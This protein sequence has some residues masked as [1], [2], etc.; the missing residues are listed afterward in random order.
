M[1]V[2]KQILKALI[3]PPTSW[4][5]L[6]LAVLIF[7][8]R[9]WA[10]KLLLAAV[11]LVIAMHSGSVSYLL[12]YPLESRYP[13]LVDPKKA[14]PYDAIVVLTAGMI[15][16]NGLIP[17]PAI[18]GT[19]FRRLDEA[20]RLYRISPRPIV[21]SGG[22]V[23]P[24]TP[25]QN[26]N[27][28]ACDYLILWGVPK[29]DVISEPRSRDTFENAVEV[30]KILREKGWKRY[31][32]VTSALHMPRS[33]LALRT[34]RTEPIPAPADFTLAGP[35]WRHPLGFFPSDGAARGM[36]VA[37]HEYVGI[38]NYYWRAFWYKG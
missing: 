15:P 38:A 13:P 37:V 27:Q 19:M 12:L 23:D 33:M 21:V 18:D 22:H 24:F 7:W 4:I 8:K 17:F 16:P 5:L 26:E 36:F 3:L 25:P 32:L 1:F 11:L 10:R 6:L 29:K 2:A 34:V 9:R 31:L 28:I 35:P 30:E 20:F 14:E